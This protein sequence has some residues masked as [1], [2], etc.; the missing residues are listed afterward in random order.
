[1]HAMSD[2]A[3]IRSVLAGNQRACE[4]L[5]RRHQDM[6]AR[7]VWRLVPSTEDREE[8][9]QDVFLKA[10]MSLH[11]FKFDSKFTTWLY[12]IAYRTAVS[13]LRSRRHDADEL[14][15]DLMADETVAGEVETAEVAALLEQA[16]SRLDVEERGI[17]TLYH[18]S[19][20]GIPEIAIIFGKPEGTIKSILFR[21]RQ[22][23]KERLM[24]VIGA[25][26]VP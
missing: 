7:F 10:F 18:I 1:M 22:R 3:L 21:V 12:S 20:C 9:C 11:T 16:I 15:E 24:P 2:E 6:V 25:G 17:L 13:R 4:Q 26:M 19:G 5:V 14:P 8:V 23:L